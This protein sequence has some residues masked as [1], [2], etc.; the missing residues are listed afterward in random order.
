MIYNIR[1]ILK[2]V[3][4]VVVGMVIMLGIALKL[5][6]LNHT[7]LLVALLLVA[8]IIIA[9]LATS[10]VLLGVKKMSISAA[11]EL[12]H[13]SSRKSSKITRKLNKSGKNDSRVKRA[14]KS[15]RLP[16]LARLLKR[17]NV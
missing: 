16:L 12:E 4:I 10:T 9:T 15:Q 8:I 13:D 6:E 17:I 14:N 5:L 7:P 1:I 3:V 11:G 2:T